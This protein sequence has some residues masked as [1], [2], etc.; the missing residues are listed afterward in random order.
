MPTWRPAD[1]FAC[2]LSAGPLLV[3]LL[4]I[5]ASAG[6]VHSQQLVVGDTREEYLRV[7]QVAG[8][9]GGGSFTV[10]PA[11]LLPAL[12]AVSPETEHP[13]RRRLSAPGRTSLG[14]D[15][16]LT[17]ADPGARFYLNS[18]FPHGTNDGPVWQGKGLTAALDVGATLTLGP[19]TLTAHPVATYAQNADFDLARVVVS[20]M[21]AYAYPW[22]KIDLPQ[23][24]GP[25]PLAEMHPGESSIHLAWRGGVAGFGTESLWWGP[26]IRNSILMGN[27]AGGFP[28]AFLGTSRPVDVGLGRLEARW[29]FGRLGLSDWF[30]TTY[31]DPGRYVTGAVVAFTPRRVP[32]LTLGLERVF[33]ASI[34]DDGIPVGEYFVLLQG[35]EKEGTGDDVRDQLFATFARW[36]FPASGFELWVEW[37]RNDHGWD[38]RDYLVEPEHAQAYTLGFRKVARLAGNRLF[39]FKGEL[40]HLERPA[41]SAVRASPTYYAHHVVLPGYT[42]HGQ[43]VGAGIGPGGN[44]QFIGAELYAVWGKA[45]A[46]VARRVHDNDA[47]CDRVS[48]VSGNHVSFDG[49][50]G[51]VLWAED[52][53]IGVQGVVTRDLNR[54]FIHFNDVWNLNLQASVRWRR[55]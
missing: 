39:A 14:A 6:T 12:S 2:R 45:E 26:G 54:Y 17:V 20:N 40:T 34:P 35:A 37:A 41:T 38:R 44:S 4:G 11:A 3:C 49:G 21:P 25:D 24:F 19:V 8:L 29:I 28:H 52:A 30:D 47:Y 48:I 23:R 1:S 51:V 33:Y 46:F 50:A 55:R 53:E 15:A 27:T 32:G 10:R 16:N 43:L 36:S 22:R 9:A 31:V 5:A 18:T 42:H 13:W 7:L